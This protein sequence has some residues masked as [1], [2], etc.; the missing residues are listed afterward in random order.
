MGDLP[1]PR[2]S[3]CPV[4][5]NPPLAGPTNRGSLT[6]CGGTNRIGPGDR[7]RSAGNSSGGVSDAERGRSALSIPTSPSYDPGDWVRSRSGSARSSHPTRP[8]SARIRPRRSPGSRPRERSRGLRTNGPEPLFT[9]RWKIAV[10]TTS[11][12]VPRVDRD[13]N[14]SP[15]CAPWR[16]RR[17]VREFRLRAGRRVLAPRD[18]APSGGRG[19]RT[20]PRGS[21]VR[22]PHPGRCSRPESELRSRR[23]IFAGLRAPAAGLHMARTRL[24]RNRRRE[25]APADRRAGGRG[26]RESSSRARPET[27]L[28]RAAPLA[29]RGAS[30]RPSRRS[31]GS[32]A[33]NQ[34][35]ADAVVGYDLQ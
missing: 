7:A 16:R 22:R 11:T 25:A 23:L 10:R 2:I 8:T 5:A 28:R 13:R 4:D 26:R 20:A 32:E 29:R 27:A 17:R 15:V 35:P 31:D 30:G 14:A 18:R 21:D 34:A 19:S 6:G 3:G 24:P 33:P 1:S 12:R 9:N